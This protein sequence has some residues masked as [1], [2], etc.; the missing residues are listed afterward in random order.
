MGSLMA[1]WWYTYT[2]EKYESQLGLWN[3]LYMESHKIHVPN[4]QP[5]SLMELMEIQD[6]HMQPMVL[7]YLP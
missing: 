6:T 1:G 4:H 5:G 7:E 2:S 3:S